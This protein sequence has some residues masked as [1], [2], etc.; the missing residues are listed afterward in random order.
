VNVCAEAQVKPLSD[1]ARPHC[2]SPHGRTVGTVQ[3]VAL[4]L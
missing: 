3:L 1:P 4:L 2:P